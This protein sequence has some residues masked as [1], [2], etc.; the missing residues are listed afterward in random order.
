MSAGPLTLVCILTVS[1]AQNPFTC[2]Q[3]HFIQSL[4]C[5][6]WLFSSLLFQ[7]KRPK[8]HLTEGK[9]L[10]PLKVVRQSARGWLHLFWSVW[11]EL[12]LAFAV[13]SSRFWCSGV[14]MC[15]SAAAEAAGWGACASELLCNLCHDKNQCLSHG[16][17]GKR[18]PEFRQR[19]LSL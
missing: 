2:A 15:N 18:S 13:L 1:F 4:H 11:R 12:D 17:L 5:F 14:W 7:L 6:C 10:P 8:I 19:P 9:V 3:W 16:Q